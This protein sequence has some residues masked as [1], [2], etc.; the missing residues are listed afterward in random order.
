MVLTMALTLFQKLNLANC[1]AKRAELAYAAPY[2]PSGGA[3]DEHERLAFREQAIAR[4]SREFETVWALARDL[5]RTH[6]L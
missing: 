5:T 4:H 1:A 3:Y 6:A 2:V